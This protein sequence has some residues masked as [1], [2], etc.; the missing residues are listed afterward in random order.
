LPNDKQPNHEFLGAA[1]AYAPA[2]KMVDPKSVQDLQ[3]QIDKVH[4]NLDKLSP[5]KTPKAPVSA[6]AS[7]VLETRL[8]ANNQ[9]KQKPSSSLPQVTPAVSLPDFGKNLQPLADQ[10]TNSVDA[11]PPKTAIG[12]NIS[13]E[14]ISSATSNDVIALTASVAS[15]MPISGKPEAID[16]H[17][18]MLSNLTQSIHSNDVW[19]K[20]ENTPDDLISLGAVAAHAGLEPVAPAV[21]NPS[22]VFISSAKSLTVVPLA[23]HTSGSSSA[24]SSDQTSAVEPVL[25]DG[26]VDWRI[27]LLM[28]AF[29]SVPTVM[30]GR[31]LLHP[32]QICHGTGQLERKWMEHGSDKPAVLLNEESVSLSHSIQFSPSQVWL[33]G[34]RFPLYKELNQSSHVAETTSSGVKG[35][36]YTHGIAKTRYTFVYDQAIQELRIDSQSTGM[37]SLEGRVGWL[38]ENT[39]FTGRCASDWF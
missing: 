12:T 16:S 32:S 28:I 26:S 1:L 20:N 11:A 29:F 39:S 2:L 22:P 5:A 7:L 25:V 30:F 8:P 36:F 17:P 15:T 13:S 24:S 14:K 21:K 19:G 35:S 33:D 31:S 34:Q 6:F 18:T 27:L 23:T 4:S 10:Q 38:E 9:L 37:G 3:F